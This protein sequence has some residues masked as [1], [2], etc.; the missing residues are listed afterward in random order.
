ML[1]KQRRRVLYVCNMLSDQI[2][3]ERALRP[4]VMTCS[5]RLI[6][7]LTACREFGTQVW[8]VSSGRNRQRGTWRWHSAKV[9]RVD[10][11]PVVFAAFWD[12]PFLTHLVTMFSL[13]LI[14]WRLRPKVRSLVFWNAMP[15]YLFALFVARLT[16]RRCILDL[17]DGLRADI[18]G[19]IGVS[20]RCLVWLWDHCS[21]AVMV[22]NTSL[23][24]QIRTR[25]AYSYYGVAQDVKTTKRWDGRLKAL[26]SGYLSTETGVEVLIDSLLILKEEFPSV[27]EEIGITVVGGGPLEERIRLAAENELRGYIEYKGRVTDREYEELLRE[28]HVGLCLKLPDNS[29][30]QSTFPSKTIEFAS[31]EMLLVGYKVSDV[32]LLFQ[33]DGAYLINGTSGRD[34]AEI[35]RMIAADKK[36]AHMRA[37]RGKRTICNRLE[38]TRVAADLSTMWLGVDR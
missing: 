10:G 28:F 22:S 11:A 4:A 9:T 15:H 7:T 38:G 27:L 29:M 19:L 34:L 23:L 12:C 13:A 17:E 5:G 33:Q 18:H 21:E 24:S 16:L 31:N 36:E 30:G 37:Q 20:Q 1:N 35:L 25:P 3:H 8:A 2:I 6:P 26:M 32:E 14:T